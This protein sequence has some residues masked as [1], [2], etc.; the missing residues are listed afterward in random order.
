[1]DEINFIGICQWCGGTGTKSEGRDEN[2]DLITSP[3]PCFHCNATGKVAS[4]LHTLDIT[5]ILDKLNDILDKCNDIFA[6]FDT[7]DQALANIS[8]KWDTI[9]SGYQTVIQKLDQ[10]IGLLGG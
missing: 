8:S 4:L 6:R 7:V 5:K 10:I 1:M 3:I 2:G 9:I